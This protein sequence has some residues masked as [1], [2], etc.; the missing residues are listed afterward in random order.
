[1]KTN[2]ELNQAIETAKTAKAT[3]LFWDDVKVYGSKA[4]ALRAL[5]CLNIE[6]AIEM[7]KNAVKYSVFKRDGKVVVQ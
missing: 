3:A 2:N 7:L 1:M 5:D 6:E 4:A